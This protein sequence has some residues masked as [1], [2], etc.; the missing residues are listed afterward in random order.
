M[1]LERLPEELQKADNL[2][3]PPGVALQVMRLADDPNAVADDLGQLIRRDPGLTLRLLRTVNSVSYGL[4]QTID[5]VERACA[6][7]GFQKAKTVALGLAIADSLP[8]VGPDAGFDL[9]EYWLRSGITCSRT[10]SAR[11]TVR[12]RS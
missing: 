11:T 12:S 2:P 1:T 9:D 5:S 8:I 10:R 4:P 7:L 6:L 3:S